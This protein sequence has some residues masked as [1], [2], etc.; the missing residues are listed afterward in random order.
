[1]IAV[2]R[3]LVAKLLTHLDWPVQRF[4]PANPT[5]VPCVVVGRPLIEPGTTDLAADFGVQVPIIVIGRTMADDDAQQELDAVADAVIDRLLPTYPFTVTADVEA[6]A[7]LV[8]PAYTIN[9]TVPMRLCTMEG[10]S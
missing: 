2:A 5:H 6:V 9:A 3:D 7:G 10:Q 4:P 1:M 8:Y